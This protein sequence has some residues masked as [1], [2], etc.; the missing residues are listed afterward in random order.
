MAHQNDVF[1]IHC[2]LMMKRDNSKIKM[3]AL[4]TEELELSESPDLLFLIFSVCHPSV[5]I[6]RACYPNIFRK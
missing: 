3:S 1:S 6:S 5:E 4:R 2:F